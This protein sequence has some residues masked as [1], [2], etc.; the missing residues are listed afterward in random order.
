[1]NSLAAPTQPYTTPKA[2]G[3]IVSSFLPACPQ[4]FPQSHKIKLSRCPLEYRKD[5][6][7]RD[8]L[9]GDLEELNLNLGANILE[10]SCSMLARSGPR[11]DRGRLV[12][13]TKNRLY[14]FEERLRVL[15][16]R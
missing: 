6:P 14:R 8:S 12:L 4:P 15:M 7:P 3:V 5:W 2:E 1:M 16:Q 9:S 10:D 13:G 11:N